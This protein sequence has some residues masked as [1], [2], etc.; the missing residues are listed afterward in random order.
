MGE[1]L[2]IGEFPTD[3]SLFSPSAIIS[4]LV[5]TFAPRGHT[6]WT[7]LDPDRKR[8]SEGSEGCERI[9]VGSGPEVYSA[10]DHEVTES[11]SKGGVEEWRS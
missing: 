5:C 7:T 6:F 9:V 3:L 4:F 11:R 10:R 2:P 8:K 1:S